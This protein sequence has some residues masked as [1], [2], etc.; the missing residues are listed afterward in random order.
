ME[1][2]YERCSGIDV[3]KTSVVACAIVPGPEGQVVKVKRS[4]G[5]MSE[6]LAAMSAWLKTM[7]VTTVAI[8]STGVYWKPV[9]NLLESQFDILVVNPERIKKLAG[10]KTD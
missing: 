9:Y 3:H 4:F 1:V 7:G 5:T 8:E 6:E 2:K 10:R